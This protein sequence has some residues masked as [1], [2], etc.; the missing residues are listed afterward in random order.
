VTGKTA[1]KDTS[2]LAAD[3]DTTMQIIESSQKE[4]AL[5]GAGRKTK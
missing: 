1:A 3:A 2:Q 5:V 4:A